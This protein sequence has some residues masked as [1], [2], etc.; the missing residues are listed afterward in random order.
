MW[1]YGWNVAVCKSLD[2]TKNEKD[3]S[4]R[5]TCLDKRNWFIDLGLAEEVIVNIVSCDFRAGFYIP[6]NDLKEPTIFLCPRVVPVKF[7]QKPIFNG[8][9]KSD[10]F[11]IFTG[12]QD[13]LW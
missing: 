4:P 3:Q 9:K 2:F 7:N 11:V 1:M 13:G 12:F 6:S 10:F 5:S 8:L